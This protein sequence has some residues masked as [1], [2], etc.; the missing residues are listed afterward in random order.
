MI[1]AQ[2]RMLIRDL[3]KGGKIWDI[4]F[5]LKLMVDWE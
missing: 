1:L 3:G 5:L 4:C 2:T